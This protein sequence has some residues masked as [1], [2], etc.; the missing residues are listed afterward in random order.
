MALLFGV[1]LSVAIAP[2]VMM[3]LTMRSTAT[4]A[5]ATAAEG[6]SAQFFLMGGWS[7]GAMTAA[8][9]GAILLFFCVSFMIYSPPPENKVV[10]ALI[11]LFS[12]C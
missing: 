5:V 9:V 2:V 3:Q 6:E 8:T 7:Y 4:K 10:D 12:C 1:A 11:P